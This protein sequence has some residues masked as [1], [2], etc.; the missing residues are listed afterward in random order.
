MAAD[1]AE[2]PKPESSAT[3]ADVD[4]EV[5]AL[6][7]VLDPAGQRAA[8]LGA[9][10]TA[11]DP[12]GARSRELVLVDLTAKRVIARRVFDSGLR[13][14]HL[15]A[16]HVY[17]TPGQGNRFHALRLTDL[18][19][20]QRL[21]LEGAIAGF[22][23]LPGNRLVVQE[24]ERLRCYS[25]DT[26]EQAPVPGCI[27]KASSALN[28]ELLGRAYRPDGHNALVVPVNDGIRFNGVVLDA[29]GK[30][31]MIYFAAGLPTVSTAPAAHVIGETPEQR[32]VPRLWGRASGDHHNHALEGNSLV[33]AGGASVAVFRGP[34]VLLREY[35][36]AATAVR[37]YPDARMRG[38]SQTPTTLSVSFGELTEGKEIDKRLLGTEPPQ[39]LSH[40]FLSAWYGGNLI[41]RDAGQSVVVTM[42][43][44]LF[45]V[46]LTKNMFAKVESPV[47][48]RH[49]PHAVSAPA[50]EKVKYTL[51]AAGGRGK[52][53]FRMLAEQTGV[54]LDPQ[55]GL[56]RI[57]TGAIWRQYCQEVQEHYYPDD[58]FPPDGRPR[59][60]PREACEHL[61]GRPI[62]GAPVAV[63]LRWAVKDDEGLEDRLSEQFVVVGPQ[64]DYDAAMAAGRAALE[65]KWAQQAKGVPSPAAAPSQAVQSNVAAEPN[66]T[67]ARASELSSA[68]EESH[69]AIAAQTTRLES[70][71]QRNAQLEVQLKELTD[72][73][74]QQE[75]QFRLLVGVA[76]VGL[77][78]TTAL[79]WWSRRRRGGDSG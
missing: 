54:A 23:S 77:A 75:Q 24:M 63:T 11:D 7:M 5:F 68:I 33:G 21:F 41:I 31:N 64:K 55:T 71:E 29:A 73:G 52:R 45:V 40:R 58:H 72:L 76:L 25:A 8:V 16:H 32:A 70:M 56:V 78:L 14:I 51:V 26:L 61:L 62:E 18:A 57:D 28:A 30:V 27:D 13:L 12:G 42:G 35:P 19:D 17:C 3:A 10:R 22:A 59:A 34:T 65:E 48:F 6:S 9:R 43:N 74:R 50:G 66:A 47:Y 67:V 15:D 39:D 46:P 38:A 79:A 2:A 69:A 49:P 4:L 53:R 20:A 60:T 44:L 36:V 1:P 37:S